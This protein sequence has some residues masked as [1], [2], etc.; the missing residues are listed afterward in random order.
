MPSPGYVAV[1]GYV[2]ATSDVDVWQ[3]KV[4][5]SV[6]QSVAPADLNVT[7]PVASPGRPAIDSVSALPYGMLAGAAASVSDGSAL[8][9]TNDA[10]VAV[11][12]L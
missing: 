3:L 6:V 4:G 7:V 12:L 11:V 1:T 2:P 9:T 5:S 10:P 8:V